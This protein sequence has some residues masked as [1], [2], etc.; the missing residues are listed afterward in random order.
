MALS[1]SAGAQKIKVKG[2]VGTI[3]G[4]TI[5]QFADDPATRGSFYVKDTQGSEM[6]YYKWVF[7][8]ELNLNYFEVYRPDDLSNILFEEQ[9]TTGFK[10]AMLT[11]FHQSGVIS[12]DGLND[13]KLDQFAQKLG[14]DFSRRREEWQNRR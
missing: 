14:K 6:L 2:D 3:D 4:A 10:K 7:F 1:L 8:Q 13:E 5:C 12:K 11:R 9:A